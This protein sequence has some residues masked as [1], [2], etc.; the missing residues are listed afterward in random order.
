MTTLPLSDPIGGY[1][2]GPNRTRKVY[3][4][5]G[6]AVRRLPDRNAHKQAPSREE[7]AP[8]GTRNGP[9]AQGTLP[10]PREGLPRRRV[11]PLPLGAGNRPVLAL[12]RG[13]GEV[14]QE[15]GRPAPA[16]LATLQ[17]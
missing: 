6:R 17:P 7:V 10:T 16:R 4:Q 14:C 13:A 11:L 1:P 3:R 9:D 5:D 8:D 2:N 15:P 12:F